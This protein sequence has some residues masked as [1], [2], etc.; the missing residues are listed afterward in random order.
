MAT[1][2]GA[3]DDLLAGRVGLEVVAAIAVY[4][5][6]IALFPMRHAA[7]DNLDACSALNE[8]A[9]VTGNMPVVASLAV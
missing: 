2:N 4:L 1:R 7:A 3:T 5:V 6:V 8:V 9:G